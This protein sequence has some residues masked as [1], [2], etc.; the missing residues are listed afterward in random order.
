MLV[1]HNSL[2]LVVDGG[3]FR[4]LR[5]RGTL[6]AVDLETLAEETKAIPA[7]RALEPDRPGRSFEGHGASRHAYKAAD[8]DQ[9]AEDDFGRHALAVA[10][11]AAGG[12]MPLILI[13]PPPMLGILRAVY[14][15]HPHLTILAEIDKDLTMHSLA[16]IVGALQWRQG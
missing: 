10:A 8:E 11:T 2:V 12:A 1:P 6:Q 15:T 9:R 5:N 16:E 13:S 14:A 3:R 4:L 7:N